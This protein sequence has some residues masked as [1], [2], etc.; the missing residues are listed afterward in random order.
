MEPPVQ[1]V[2]DEAR[3]IGLAVIDDAATP[4]GGIRRGSLRPSAA[5]GARAG[6]REVRAVF[7]GG[8]R[9]E[10]LCAASGGS[11]RLARRSG[12]GR[13]QEERRDEKE[14]GD[15]VDVRVTSKLY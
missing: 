12:Y 14:E 4:G 13:S 6:Q 3:R 11:G 2:R 15:V 5:E 8:C 9:G 7:G 1:V 10:E